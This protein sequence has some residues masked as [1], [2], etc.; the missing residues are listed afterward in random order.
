MPLIRA[1]RRIVDRLRETLFLATSIGGDLECPFCKWHF[2]RF[3]PIAAAKSPLFEREHVVGGGH[4]EHSE[5]PWCGSFERER[6]IYLYLRDHTDVFSRP[7]R[8]M[9]VAPEP[10]LQRVLRGAANIDYVSTDLASPR[11]D[12]KC[13]LTNVPLA[14]DS[15]DVILCNHVLEHIPDDAAAMRELFRLLKPGG[16]A[17]LQV[18]LA[19]TRAATEYDPAMTTPQQRLLHYGQRD[20][21]RL[22][23][24]DYGDRLAAAGFSV[25]HHDTRQRSGDD[26]VRRH[27]LIPDEI[28]YIA[29]KR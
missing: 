18:P 12:L 2:R 23:G 27:A 21:V 5:C 22:Y 14:S 17:I 13:D 15:F 20:H 28:L 7:L 24:R 3:V 1:A 26:Y 9:H 16:W 4:F 11:A 10:N 29:R 19:V 25:E 8:L 6:Q